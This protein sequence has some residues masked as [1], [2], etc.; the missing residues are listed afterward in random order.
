M[1]SRSLMKGFDKGRLKAL[2]AVFFLALALP[3]G[4]LIWQAYSQLKWE[5]FHQYR[6]LA[7]NLT[8]RIDAQLIEMIST[9]DS[10][11]FADYSFLNVTGDIRYNFVQRSPLAAFPVASDLPGVM[12][13][14]QVDTSGEFS[15]PL[16]PPAGTDAE[17]LGVGADEYA[18]RQQLAQRIQSVLA[19]NRLVRRQQEEL[20]R[21]DLVAATPKTGEN[22]EKAKE[23]A[24][25]ETAGS[26]SRQY[27]AESPADAPE[28]QLA[29]MRSVLPESAAGGFLD[30]N[31]A[32]KDIADDL[33]G[34]QLPSAVSVD[35]A[36]SQQVFDLLNQPGEAA[37][38]NR[39]FADYLAGTADY[40][41]IDDSV[42]EA[43]FENERI[44]AIGKVSE[45]KFDAGL[46][47][48]SESLEFAAEEKRPDTGNA[49]LTGRAK[50]REQSA[51]PETAAPANRQP[52]PNISGTAGLRIST[53]ESEIDPLEFSQLD[54]GHF[55]FF[56]D[57]WREGERY[58]QGL[59]VDQNAFVADTI[60]KA[61]YDS[62]LSAMSNLIVGY[63]DDVIRL[64]PG[65]L[66]SYAGS[67]AESQG[68][69]L[70]SR[71]LSTPLANLELIF[72]INQLPPG[73]GATVLGW[74]TLV[75]ALVLVGGFLALY[76]LGLSQINLARQQQ[77]F[78]SA[79]S[80]ELKTPLTSIRMYGEM[81][82]EGWADETKRQGYYEFIHD[83][84]ERLTR[85]ISNVLQLAKITRNEPNFEL[86][87]V[88]A[89]ELMS[90]IESKISGQ[91]ERAGFA[92]EFRRDEDSDAANI[93]L[94][95]D[96]FTQIII[97]LVDNASSSPG[98]PTTKPLKS[99]AGPAATG[100]FN[101]ACGI[102]VLA[103][104]KTR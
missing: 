38:I 4:A 47:Q 11:S 102:M 19:D 64:Y 35:S 91:V 82:K 34:T 60:E 59:L 53:F 101:S 2:L 52:F 78:V 41:E 26:R 104:P 3:T 69:L 25:L 58:V 13:Y 7:D 29:A 1:F 44:N 99:A 85:M 8:S 95:E 32:D 71:R 51:L 86:K 36:Y 87:P 70:Y 92:L 15:T 96:C 97:N 63:Q 10:R 12:G 31:T 20:L 76:R 30:Q 72:S 22:P 81:L 68:E 62:P 21:R 18:D 16:L 80:H 66:Y 14:F 100:R 6:G 75:L 17:K 89:G 65:T 90:N 73:P 67:L 27:A 93:N 43:V 61:F 83:E 50:R 98:T 37:R 77:D 57:V 56:R 45:L 24:S 88:N 49:D 48:K 94:D 84:S 54:S 55:V 103:S 5:A 39:G 42:D 79:V 9:A 28:P 33:S 46:Q 23:N 74:V 40:L